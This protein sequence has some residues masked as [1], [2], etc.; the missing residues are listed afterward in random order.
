MATIK[1][2]FRAS[3]VPQAEGTLYFQ[4]I[5]QRSVRCQSTAYHIFPHEWDERRSAML[6]PPHGERR[7]QLLLVQ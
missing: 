7:A 6:I 4:V 2:K 5:H 3:S 1:L